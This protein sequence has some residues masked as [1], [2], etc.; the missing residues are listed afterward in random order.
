MWALVIVPLAVVAIAHAVTAGQMQ[1][2]EALHRGRSI[3]LAEDLMEEILALPYDPVSDDGIQEAARWL[4]DDATD[5]AGFSEGASVVAFLDR[6]GQAEIPY[7]DEYQRFSRSVAMTECRCGGGMPACDVPL[8]SVFDAANP[9]AMS[10]LTITVTVMDDQ[11]EMV[12][13]TRIRTAEV[14]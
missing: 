12:A 11:R 2:L 14:E 6:A 8:C 13:L 3:A 5:Y 1:S 4:Y 7:P 10:V 9:P